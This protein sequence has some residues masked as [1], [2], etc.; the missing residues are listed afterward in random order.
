MNYLFRDKW[1]D[2]PAYAAYPNSLRVAVQYSLPLA[3][4][5]PRDQR[6]IERSWRKVWRFILA[7]GPARTI[8]KIRSKRLQAYINGDYHVVLAVG[9]ALD[10]GAGQA[11]LCLGTRH[12]RAAEMMLFRRELVIP[13]ASVPAEEACAQAAQEAAEDLALAGS[14][15]DSFAGYNFYSDLAPP[16]AA[17][18]FIGEVAARLEGRSSLGPAGCAPRRTN[19]QAGKS[20]GAIRPPA[21]A[22]RAEAR[23]WGRGAAVIAAGDYARTEIIPALRRAR[24]PL[25]T[26]VDLEPYLAEHARQTCGFARAATDWR[27]A[28][29]PPETEIV[30]V[31]S[32]HDSHAEIAAGA[33]RAGKKVF[34]EK[35]PAVTREDL[36]LL[37][38]AAGAP[39][40]VLEIGY[41]RRFAPLTRKAKELL[42]RA[43]GPTSVLCVVKEVEIPDEHWYRWPKEGTR[44][45]GNM[46]HW[47]DLAVHLIGAD[48]APVEM[49]L[50]G[51][52]RVPHPD[53]EK[54]VSID[55]SDG[56]TA[57]IITTSRGDG[58]LGVQEWIE[59]RR[60]DLTITIDDYRRLVATQSGKVLCRRWGLRD[61]G[62]AAMYRESLERMKRNEPAL[63]TPGELRLTTLLTI[64]ATEMVKSGVRSTGARLCLAYR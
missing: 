63:Y 37:M 1:R 15:W 60:G 14:G 27:A 32:Y 41:N 52:Q 40:R 54:G 55:F 58:T 3:R 29:S 35:P 31:A 38:E 2:V 33:L 22:A 25:H 44:I 57:T 64:E 48:G 49:T 11:A 34:L 19:E 47:I 61:K 21:G 62:H 20:H 26:I 30:I 24:V 8:R 59:I 51:P 23:L 53:E 4:V 50:L 7:E 5:A 17:V 45:T 39:G 56:S 18:R 42:S 28:V 36:A 43:A 10:G 9:K 13:L 16:A 6:V 46:C 12:P